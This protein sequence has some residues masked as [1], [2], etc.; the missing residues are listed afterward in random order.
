VSFMVLGFNENM[1]NKFL[2][3]LEIIIER[4]IRQWGRKLVAS[5]IHISMAC[6]P[7]V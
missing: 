4:L 3:K 2:C 1:G 6:T 5:A 7:V